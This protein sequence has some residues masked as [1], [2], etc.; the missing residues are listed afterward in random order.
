MRKIYLVVILTCAASI[1]L[2]ISS[3]IYLDKY[4]HKTYHYS[5]SVDG[6]YAGS[7]KIDTFITEERRIY[8]SVSSLPFNELF[9]EEKS[10][11]DLGRNYDLQ[12]YQKELS[13]NGL[14]YTFYL[15][16]KNGS[17]S[18]LCRGQSRFAYLGNIP[19]WRKTFIFEEDS[20]L[21]YLP[22]IE[23]YDFKRGGSQGFN[24]RI[25]FPYKFIPPL[26]R[27]VT[28]TSIKDEYLKIDRRKIKTENLILKIKGYPQGSV[29]IAKSDRSVVL[30][31]IPSTGLKIVRSFI[32]NEIKPKERV[33]KSDAYISKD[34]SFGSKNNQLAG[35]LTIPK[36]EG[37]SPAIL[38]V[39]GAGPHDRN[40]MG[41][42]DS[43]ADYLSA[44]GF[45]VLR[46]DK[47]GI[48]SSGGERIAPVASDDEYGDLVSALN[49]LASQKDV[50]S[51][52]I[53][54]IAHSE[55]AF[56]ALRLASENG[57][58]KK[59][60]LMAPSIYP[61]GKFSEEY[62]RYIA[63]K[64]KWG[65]DYV[66]LVKMCEKETVGKASASTR[67]WGYIMGKRCY[68]K[69][70][71]PNA[72]ASSAAI[73]SV[74][75]SVLILYGKLDDEMP[76]WSAQ[77]IEKALADSGNQDHSIRYYSYLGHF[78][79]KKTRDGVYRT[80]YEPDKEVLVNI[81]DWLNMPVK[82]PAKEDISLTST[83]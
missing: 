26:K 71:R 57:N 63:E 20:L 39:C 7:T 9:T 75:A 72:S 29:W 30:L 35:T 68:L 59:V 22:I 10:R 64:W 47:R 80:F 31:E 66:S 19:I 27:F 49:Y 37:S 44:N 28:L 51:K 54:V 16:N 58:I 48:A 32:P 74:T 1:L 81:K 82:E 83:G 23:N 17:I 40:Y 6:Q 5:V 33:I 78:L 2:F 65:E 70:M 8:K 45:C 69:N 60:V 67:D 43:M 77:V 11:L 24:S 50:D 21:T 25:C 42:F 36:K 53:A 79:G 55:G 41:L 14:T 76:S 56:N 13:A 34:I 52:N 18:F 15:E 4:N 46:F 62:L 38:L 61:E 73:N 3:F 12:D